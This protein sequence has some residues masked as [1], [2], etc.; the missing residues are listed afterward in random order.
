MS[1]PALALVTIGLLAVAPVASASD[2]AASGDVT[3]QAAVIGEFD[4]GGAGWAMAKDGGALWVQV[5]P[6]V[7]AIVRIDVATGF[8]IPAVPGGWKAKAGPEGL[9]VV[10]CDWLVR[11][12]PAT[13]SEMLRV[14]MGGAFALGDGAAWLMNDAGLHRIDPST[15]T[16]GEPIGP[17][18]ATVCGSSKDSRHRLRERLA[19][20]Q[21]GPRRPG[22]NPQRR[23]DDHPD[24]LRGP[25]VHGDG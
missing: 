2:P 11:V 20:M 9:W 15:G 6:P 21:G 25:H 3:G 22:G 18:L 7:D 10:C 24:G 1:R 19:G 12:D 5:D 23:R 8:T 4:V 17:S 13:G 14:P 16:V